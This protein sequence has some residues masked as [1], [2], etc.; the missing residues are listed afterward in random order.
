MGRDAGFF[1]HRGL[2][3]IPAEAL[4]CGQIDAN[5][6]TALQQRTSIDADWVAGF[7]RA[8]SRYC[9]RMDDLHARASDFFLP[10]RHPNF[11]IV[12]APAAVRP[13]T[14]PFRGSSWFA[15]ASDFR[16][17]TSSD[18][19]AVFVLV[20]LDGLSR[21]QSPMRALARSLPY[22][23]TLSEAQMTDL[24]AGCALTQ[25]SDA[26]AFRTL[27][28]HLQALRR[29]HH[30]D[31]APLTAA[32]PDAEA[33]APL[34]EAGLLVPKDL[35]HTV[36]GVANVF[37]RAAE[38]ATHRYLAPFTDEADDEH[39]DAL[40]G[41]L[42]QAAPQVLV[43]GADGHVLWDP[44]APATTDA[45]QQAATGITKV[46]AESLRADLQTVSDCSRAFLAA[47]TRPEQLKPPSEIEAEGGTYL[48]A[49]RRLV[50]YSLEQP[51]ILTLIE[52]APPFHRE[53]L[54]ARTIHEWGHLAVDAGWVRVPEARRN[55][56]RAA[57]G[58]LEA[59][60]DALLRAA[61]LS[62]HQ[63]A[64]EAASEIIGAPADRI[65]PAFAHIILQRASDYAS[66]LVAQ[67]FLDAELRHYLRG[68]LR[69]LHDTELGQFTQLA[70][71]AYAFQYLLLAGIEK[72]FEYFMKVTGARATFVEPR[73]ASEAQL[74]TLFSAVSALL[75]CF[76]VD[77]SAFRD[78]PRAPPTQ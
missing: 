5:C 42:R 54:A 18:E 29:M 2:F 34:R 21:T 4:R 38:A 77:A 16:A 35:M 8:F 73:I 45:L 75:G 33:Y 72:P 3:V 13:Y 9:L 23:L 50:V 10:A 14:Q 40:A 65:G 41:W 20:Y 69:S 6:A 70:Q 48:H 52:P 46:A 49:T 58:Q 22:L 47:L 7:N 1:Q 53:L 25:R 64:Y 19:L 68:N 63:A 12:T 32:A 11:V 44:E 74:E 43:A 17:T 59:Q 55:E 24:R 57:Q 31:L 51:G 56:F 39:A 60:F 76:E 30:P 61:P 28:E 26:V 15:Y 66:N 37:E 71:Q 36:Q 62:Q 27:G 67:R 78:L